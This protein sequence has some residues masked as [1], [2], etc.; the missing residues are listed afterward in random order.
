MEPLEPKNDFA[1]SKTVEVIAR[2][3]HEKD[4][5]IGLLTAAYNP[6]VLSE[7]A[8]KPCS[9]LSF[10]PIETVKNEMS[11]AGS[12]NISSALLCELNPNMTICLL[13]SDFTYEDISSAHA[14]ITAPSRLLASSAPAQRSQPRIAGSSE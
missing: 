3:A 5:A 1:A 11:I 12:L 6:A 9:T 2:A 13:S 10:W 4:A 7:S 14:Y 8:C